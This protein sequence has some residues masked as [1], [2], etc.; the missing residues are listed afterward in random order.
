MNPFFYPYH[1]GTERVLLEIYKRLAKRHNVSV[2]SA[3]FKGCGGISEAFGIKIVRLRSRY[4]NF[5]ALPLPWPIMEGLNAAIKKENADICHINNR[6]LYYNGTLRA[7]AEGRGRLALTLHNALPRGIDAITDFG[8]LLYDLA[9][10]RRIME[11]A[12]VIIG[13]TKNVVETTVPERLL[14][15]THV[16]FNGIDMERFRPRRRDRG[17]AES[18][19]EKIGG[20]EVILNVARLTVQKGQIYMMRAFAEILKGRPH[21]ELLIIGRGP[22]KA[23]LFREA[24]RLGIKR[25]FTILSDVN[26]RLFPYYYNASSVFVLP[27]LYE[28]ASIAML[29][30]LAS[31]TPTIASRV[32]GIPEMMRNSGRYTRPKDAEGIRDSIEKTLGDMK[33]ANALARRGI[34]LMKG[35]HDWD[36]IAN[37]YEALFLKLAT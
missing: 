30:A 20:D 27:S 19:R 36:K 29:E 26:E 14:G 23:R 12:G 1:G 25:H 35:E 17:E 34:K 10:G 31:G 2:L 32:G 24:E 16:V 4:L 21:S 11:K 18:I 37:E 9:W 28:P 13:I 6:Y 8:G 5:P 3:E 33:G 22:L 15:K 7:I